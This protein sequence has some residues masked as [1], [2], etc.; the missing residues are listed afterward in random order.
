MWLIYF[1]PTIVRLRQ[2]KFMRDHSR[3]TEFQSYHSAIKTKH[4]FLVLALVGHFNPT[5]VRLRPRNAG[6]F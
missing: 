1:N 4:L 3:A 5:I 2:L 6:R